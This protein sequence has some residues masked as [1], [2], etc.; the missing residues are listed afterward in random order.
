[1]LGMLIHGS[2]DLHTRTWGLTASSRVAQGG[3]TPTWPEHEE[4]HRV[5]W[6]LPRFRRRLT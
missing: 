5:A 6:G 4:A 1:M 3:P 2:Q